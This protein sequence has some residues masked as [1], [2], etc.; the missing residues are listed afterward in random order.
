[1]ETEYTVALV[2][3]AYAV[4]ADDTGRPDAPAQARAG[5]SL[6]ERVVLAAA[7]V[8]SF[9]TLAF[10]AGLLVIIR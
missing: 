2:M 3:S 5:L 1:M 9:A 10:V 6:V 4:V 7:S 8:S